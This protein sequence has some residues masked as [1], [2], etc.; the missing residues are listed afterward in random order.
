MFTA[1]SNALDLYSETQIKGTIVLVNTNQHLLGED[2]YV[3]FGRY[4]VARTMAA[5]FERAQIPDEKN[6]RTTHLII[7]ESAPY[8]DESFDALLTRVRQFGLKVTVAFQHLDQL[9]DKLRNSVAGQTSIK[10]I[11]GLSPIDERRVAAQVRSEPEFIADLA[12]DNA[13]PP[14]WSEWAVYVDGLTKRAVNLQFPFFRMERHPTMTPEQHA[15]LLRENLVRVSSVSREPP[16][17]AAPRAAAGPSPPA[18]DVP[19]TRSTSEAGETW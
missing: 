10:Y 19:P 3:L 16:Q 13:N 7:D 6:R 12:K 18:Q 4:I 8:F 9:S 5:M 17:A 11:G 15:I 14:T 2:G 1:S